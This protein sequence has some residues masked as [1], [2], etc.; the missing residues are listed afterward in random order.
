MIAEGYQFVTLASDSRHMAAKAA[1]EV[2]VVRKTGT[3]AGSCRRTS[4]GP[5]GRRAARP[6][7][8]QPGRLRAASPCPPTGGGR[9]AVAL[10]LLPD[11][12]GRACFLI[13]RRAATLRSTPASGRCRAGASIAGETA[14]A[15]RCASCRRKW[16]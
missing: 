8:R 13:T 1:E 11:D 4:A 9:A 10:V 16:A 7:A 14:E 6:G 5:A 2:G 3:K 15:R 12:E